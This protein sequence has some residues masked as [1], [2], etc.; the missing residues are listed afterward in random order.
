MVENQQRIA[1][2][3]AGFGRSG[4]T[5]VQ[6]ALAEANDLR[7]V[8]EPLH[9]WEGPTASRYANRL[10]LPEDDEPELRAHLHRYFDGDFHSLWADYRIARRGLRPGVSD[11][12][13]LSNAKKRIGKYRQAARY[14][15]RYYPRRRLHARI[16]K[17]VR[18]NMMLSWI[19]RQFNARIVL[20]V[21]HPAAVVLSQMASPKAWKPA[22]Q[23]SAFTSDER[24]VAQLSPA[25]RAL[26]TSPLGPVETYAAVWCVEN[27]I[28]IQ[29]ARASGL[30][31]V[32]YEEL[33]RAGHREWPRIATALELANVPR[34][35]LVEKPSQQAWGESYENPEKLR[36]Y[37][38]WMDRIDERTAD[39]L[40][41][42]LDAAD[43]RLYTVSDPLPMV[44]QL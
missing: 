33:V 42:V 9:K 7:A 3:V 11:L 1:R 20:I 10:V 17:F 22:V 27:E 14:V 4:T 16:V 37:A 6:D 12:L 24:L 41:A 32:F 30:H 25:T 40:Q 34:G 5:W 23:L 13:S 35:E 26:I 19:Q 15:A 38:K 29:Q 8:F 18:A 36:R 39:R 21:R 43:S 31:V 2:V 44:S 28:A